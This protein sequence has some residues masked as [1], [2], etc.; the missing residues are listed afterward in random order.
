ML[1][2]TELNTL[3]FGFVFVCFVCTQLYKLVDEFGK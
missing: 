2:V 3:F 1:V